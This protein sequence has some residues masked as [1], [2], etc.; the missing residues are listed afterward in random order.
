VLLNK[1][2]IT[3]EFLENVIKQFAEVAQTYIKNR[4]SLDEISPIKARQ[5]NDQLMQLEKCY[6]DAEG[7]KQRPHMKNVM[8][9]TDNFDQYRGVLAPGIHDAIWSATQCDNRCQEECQVQEQEQNIVTSQCKDFC[10]TT[11]CHKQWEDV[12]QQLSVL[13]YAINSATLMLKDVN[14]LQ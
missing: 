14:G 3:L 11:D 2:G 7:L 13:I 1:N 4:D 10:S 9:G 12:K 6:T 5:L 8:F